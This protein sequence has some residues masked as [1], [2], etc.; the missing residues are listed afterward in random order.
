MKSVTMVDVAKAAGVSLSTVSRVIHNNG[1]VAGEKRSVVEKAVV[2]LGYVPNGITRKLES[3]QSK[4][5]GNVIPSDFDNGNPL[6]Q[7]LNDAISI[8]AY[9]SGFKVMTVP[10]SRDNNS[11]A[12]LVDDS[13]WDMFCG[14]IFTS[15][16]KPDVPEAFWN[17]L[18]KIELPMVMVER[19]ISYFGLNK[20][21]SNNSEGT[22][23]AT[24]YLAGN[25]HTKIAFIGCTPHYDVERERLAGYQ[26]AMK[27]HGC[28]Y[29]DEFVRLVD[30]YTPSYGYEAA[31]SL[32]SAKVV[33]TAVV[34]CCDIMAAGAIQYFGSANI[35]VPE[36]ISVI[37]HDDSIAR[38]LTPPLT[39]IALPADEMA[40]VAVNIISEQQSKAN[41]HFAKTISISPKLIVRQTVKS[42]DRA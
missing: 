26:L 37:G 18:S 42:L 5:I 11:L 12:E 2:A 1:Y 17:F 34:V 39:T 22:Y 32:F 21:L 41:N 16:M 8:A 4:I 19:V 23:M 10:A 33:P 29:R 24:N 30:D 27:Y 25:G 3:R 20:V 7:R 40:R 15:F 6:F 35:K 14:V 13:S 38:F 28:E 9:E 36:D 31:K